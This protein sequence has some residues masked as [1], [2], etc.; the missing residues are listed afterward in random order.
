MA[1]ARS[2]PAVGTTDLSLQV[3]VI[4]A[5]SAIAV[6][7]LTVTRPMPC[8]QA[9]SML[10]PSATHQQPARA[11]TTTFTLVVLLQGAKAVARLRLVIASE[12]DP[13]AKSQPIDLST[14]PTTPYKR[15]DPTAAGTKLWT[16]ITLPATFKPGKYS[17]PT[18]LRACNREDFAMLPVCSASHTDLPPLAAFGAACLAE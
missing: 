7:A 4:C 5:E 15:D 12:D 8:A 10:A 11:A 2:S 16:R 1:P 13:K 6:Y 3:A 17:F 9:A 18:A 14:V